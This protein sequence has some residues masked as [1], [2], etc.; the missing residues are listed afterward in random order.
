MRRKKIL[1]FLD[2]ILVSGGNSLTILL[3][4]KF[5]S[6]ED[7]GILVVAF[8]LY[9]ALLLFSIALVYSG[10][11]I[12]YKNMDNPSQ[13]IY[14]V[15]LFHTLFS[16]F[17]LICVVM[18]Y[19]PL[20]WYFSYPLTLGVF[21]VFLL[22]LFFQQYIDFARRTAYVIS[23]ERSAF[24]YSFMTYV[25]RIIFLYVI[26]PKTLSLVFM[27]LFAT[28][29]IPFLGV[30]SKILA[31]KF[32]KNI[33]LDIAVLKQ[34][35]IFSKHFVQTVPVA[36]LMTYLPIFFLGIFKGA[37][38]VAILGTFKNITNMANVFVEVIEV[39]YIARW[40]DVFK[41][42]GRDILKKKIV[43]IVQIFTFFWAI[44]TLIIYVGYDFLTNILG[45]LYQGYLLILFIL[46]V[47]YLIYFYGRLYVLYYRILSDTKVERDYTAAGFLVT[48]M[49]AY[50]I[51]KFGLVGASVSFLLMFMIPL[52][53]FLIFK[54]NRS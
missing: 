22:F 24:M 40:H 27:I 31:L 28:N 42:Q 4:A 17:F 10:V 39:T 52:G 13:Y 16:L 37:A 20:A 35:L 1:P 6:L 21:A 11:S 49:S 7:Q 15:A 32:Q 33:T 3:C 25:P 45:S 54:G 51:Y 9:I 14:S 30:L 18:L 43:Q 44:G 46:W 50:V 26:Q 48:L 19:K 8:S 23:S 34:H 47:S 53:F 12:L 29:L 2:Q 38:S 41:E 36:W 5:L